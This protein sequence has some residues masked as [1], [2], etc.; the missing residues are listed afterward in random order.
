M[1]GTELGAAIRRLIV[2]CHGTESRLA[3]HQPVAAWWQIAKLVLRVVVRSGGPGLSQ[4]AL[5]EQAHVGERQTPA[6]GA[7]NASSDDAACCR[8]GPASG[9][10]TIGICSSALNGG[11]IERPPWITK[12]VRGRSSPGVNVMISASA[13]ADAPG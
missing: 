3:C 12:S 11:P 6:V 10:R 7:D 4:I 9:S 8:G 2:G 1:S 13:R 5:S